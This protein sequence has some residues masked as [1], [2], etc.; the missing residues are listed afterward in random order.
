M[1]ATK[2]YAESEERESTEEGKVKYSFVSLWEL[3]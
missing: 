3:L 1:L 2:N